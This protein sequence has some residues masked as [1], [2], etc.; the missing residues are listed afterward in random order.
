MFQ[1]TP[2]YMSHVL[3]KL[4]SGIIF[5]HTPNYPGTYLPVKPDTTEQDKI[6]SHLRQ[7]T[8]LDFKY[9]LTISTLARETFSLISNKLF[10]YRLSYSNLDI[11][12]RLIFQFYYI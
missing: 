12:A 10:I 3:T 1:I 5:P 11:N 4:L 8:A 9:T 6:C 7:E 2:V